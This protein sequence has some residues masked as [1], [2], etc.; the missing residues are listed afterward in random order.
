MRQQ[1]QEEAA[2]KRSWLQLFSSQPLTRERRGFIVKTYSIIICMLAITTAVT[3]G[4]YSNDDAKLWVFRNTWLY[5]VAL[6]LTLTMMCYFTCF[7][8]CFLS[9]PLN[10]VILFVFTLVHS[11][12]IAAITCRYEEDVVIA[13]ALC[14]MGMFIGL[15]VYA[16]CL[17]TDMTYMGGLLSA[18]TIL[19]LIFLILFSFIS[20]IM[21]LVACCV[22]VGLFSLWIVHDTQLIV[23]GKHRAF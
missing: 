11:Y 4:I 9:V 12:V 17:K 19:V 5:V 2:N 7:Y 18:F 21:Y 23:G 15:T 20:R 1:E 14:T 3:F 8:Q 16:C 22:V 6:V 10:Y 13:A